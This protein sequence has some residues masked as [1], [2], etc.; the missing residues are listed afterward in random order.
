MS[1]S[2]PKIAQHHCKWLKAALLDVGPGERI[3]ATGV[4]W[5]TYAMLSEFRDEH[6]RAVRIAFL[7]GKIEITKTTYRTER[8]RVRV[9]L[10]ISS[11]FHEFQLPCIGSR[12]TTF[13]RS[14]NKVGFE[15]NDSYYIENYKHL[16]G[17]DDI[18]LAI[19]PP[20][21]LAL[22]LD[23]ESQFSKEPVYAGLGIPELWLWDGTAIAFR[24][25]QADGRYAQITHSVA[26]PSASD[27]EV[28][29]IVSSQVVEDD[30]AFMRRARDWAS[31]LN[32][33][34][35]IFLQS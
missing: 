27:I 6:R 14:E 11:L 1:N 9:G 2:I 8:L 17:L 26:I 23:F 12:S 30:L 20:P 15:A 25:L 3:Y 4:P 35:T 16:L 34:P 13:Q 33:S 28:T 22:E 31:R 10:V 29:E 32:E 7:D 18:D 19:H 5:D 21:D 24:R